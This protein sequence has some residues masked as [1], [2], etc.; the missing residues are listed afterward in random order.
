[1]KWSGLSR[2]SRG[3]EQFRQLGKVRRDPLGL[4][5]SEQLGR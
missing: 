1:L 3:A 5:L 4:V 2:R